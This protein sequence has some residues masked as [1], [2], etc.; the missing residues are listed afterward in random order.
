MHTDG[1]SLDC[2]QLTNPCDNRE[3]GVNMTRDNRER[4]GYMTLDNRE[5]VGTRTVRNNSDRLENTTS[6]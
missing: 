2:V 4:G 6:W 1:T 3:M 5:S